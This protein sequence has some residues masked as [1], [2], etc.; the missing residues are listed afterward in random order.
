MMHLYLCAGSLKSVMY[1]HFL[2]L[3]DV[4]S[5]SIL[6]LGIILIITYVFSCIFSVVCIAP[7]FNRYVCIAWHRLYL[8]VL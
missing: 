8:C 2:M 6:I 1:R 7:V 5:S 4:M 3:F